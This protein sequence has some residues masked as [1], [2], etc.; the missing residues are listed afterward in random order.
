MS[1]PQP[2]GQE[3]RARVAPDVVQDGVDAAAHFNLFSIPEQTAGKPAIYD[4]NNSGAVV[5]WDIRENLHRFLIS[6]HAPTQDAPLRA[7]NRVAERLASFS[8]RWMLMPDDY[9]ALPGSDP[10]ATRFDPSR[11]QRF[12]LADSICHF[13]DGDD[14]FRAFGTGHT[15]PSPRGDGSRK[16][17]VMAVG[18]ILDGFGKFEGITE[19]T[20]CYCGTLCPDSGFTGNLL[21][22]VMD[23]AEHFQTGASLPSPQAGPETEA[24]V[25]Y[26]LFRGQAI[27][28]DPVSPNIGPGGQPIGLVV[29]QGLRLLEIDCAAR[30]SGGLRTT[31]AV[32]PYVGRITARV[33][34][35]PATP[36]GS[37]LQPIPFTAED[38]F[39]W[40]DRGGEQLSSF[41]ANSTEGRVFTTHVAGQPAIRFGGI[42]EILSGAG[43]F[44]GMRGL[45]TDN[46]VVVFAPHVSASLYL[47]R[48]EDPD[49]RHRTGATKRGAGK[50]A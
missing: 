23:R 18:T 5:G 8:H 41:T 48:L 37:A 39:V 20:F 40:Q 4:R 9:L 25:T 1:S 45:M 50:K 21:L 38:D 49:G 43:P 22:R 16:V 11:S 27:P 17:R 12:V 7:T 28:S 31:A 33:V 29:E 47:L 15:L 26:I 35:N 42:G 30:G 10:P 24:G 3:A 36:G 44:Q 6:T 2:A 34:F 32:G 19:G 46:S 13:R 14:G